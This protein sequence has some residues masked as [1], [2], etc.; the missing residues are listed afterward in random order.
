[1]EEMTRTQSPEKCGNETKVRARSATKASC[2]AHL[3]ILRGSHDVH[4]TVRV[5]AHMW[6]HRQCALEMHQFMI[7]RRQRPCVQAGVL[8]DYAASGIRRRRPLV[9]L[10]LCCRLQ[11]CFGRRPASGPENQTRVTKTQEAPAGKQNKNLELLC[12]IQRAID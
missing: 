10:T 4:P 5:N 1:M 3:A 6:N 8:V 2:A 9:E 7:S 11:C 12:Q